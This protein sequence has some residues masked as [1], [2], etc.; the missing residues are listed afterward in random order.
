M[1][2]DLLAIICGFLL[3]I[4]VTIPFNWLAIYVVEKSLPA[5]ILHMYYIISFFLVGIFVGF[6]GKMKGWKLSLIMFIT[7][8]CLLIIIV[9]TAGKHIDSEKIG[10]TNYIYKVVFTFPSLIGLI[11]TFCGGIIGERFRKRSNANRKIP[12]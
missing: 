11:V 12:S 10:Y 1:K 5:V 4:V 3:W 2:R 8:M 9:S 7:L 6:F